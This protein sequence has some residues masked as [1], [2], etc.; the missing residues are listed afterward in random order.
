MNFRAVAGGIV[1]TAI[2]RANHLFPKSRVKPVVSEHSIER[3][4]RLD[5]KRA[6]AC[7]DLIS[8]VAG[9]VV[10]TARKSHHDDARSIQGP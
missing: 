1:R 10:R 7:F 4:K 2:Q 3:R 6:I 9:D 5:L 8:L